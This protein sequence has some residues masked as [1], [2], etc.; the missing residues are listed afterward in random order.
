MSI[1][2][3]Q[4]RKSDFQ[5]HSPRDAGWAGAKP[6]DGIA[7]PDATS[8]EKARLEYCE[9]FLKKC[10]QENLKAIAITDHHEGVYPYLMMKAK[11]SIEAAGAPLDLWIFPGMELTCKDSC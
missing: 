6:E 7:T 11:K 2:G 10:V 5:I 9:K 1:S 8:I 4:F 3:A